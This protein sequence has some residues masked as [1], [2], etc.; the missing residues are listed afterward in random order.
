METLGI[1]IG[2]SGIKGAPVNL[3]TGLLLAER[4]RVD[5]PQPA[6]PQAMIQAMAEVVRH[7]DWK[8]PI[9][10]GFPGIVKDGRV[11]SAANI[12]KSWIGLSCREMLQDATGCPVAVMNDADAAGLA[13]V[14][15]GAGHS[16]M[17]TLIVLTLGTGIG[18]AL[19]LDGKPIPNTE[20]GHLRYDAKRVFEDM[21]SERAKEHFNMKWREW[22]RH[23]QEYLTHLELLFSPDLFIVGGGASRKFEKWATYISIK[24]PL[25]PAEMLNMAGIVGAAMAA[26]SLLPAPAT[27]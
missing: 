26:E 18:S 1:D 21:C 13:E 7:F 12:D 24:T 4:H 10:C 17:G 22:A 3:V 9:G 8:G 15:F 5:T 14:K 23:F 6:T 11:W 16:R 27:A 20:F 2:G 19:F 25:V